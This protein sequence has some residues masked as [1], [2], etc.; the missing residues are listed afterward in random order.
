MNDD[1]TINM[2]RNVWKLLYLLCIYVYSHMNVDYET[3]ISHIELEQRLSIKNC[4]QKFT[5]IYLNI[6][7]IKKHY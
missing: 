3:L 4:S 7:E 5:F 2:N 6:L 1:T